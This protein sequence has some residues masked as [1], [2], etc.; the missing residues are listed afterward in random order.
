MPNHTQY[1]ANLGASTQGKIPLAIQSDAPRSIAE[2]IA[3]VAD[4]R[5][6]SGSSRISG[7]L[8]RSLPISRRTNLSAVGVIGR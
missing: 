8:G 7:A 5:S 3:G 1:E 4:K 6:R 2:L